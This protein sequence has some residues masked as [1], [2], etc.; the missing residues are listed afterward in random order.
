MDCRRRC[1]PRRRITDRRHE[2]AGTLSRPRNALVW[3]RRRGGRRDWR[4]AEERDRDRRRRRR[5]ARARTQCDGRA[6]HAWSR[7]DLAVRV[8]R[9]RASRYARRIERSRRSRRHVHGRSEPQSLTS[10]S[11]SVAGGRSRT[12]CLRCTWWPRGC[13]RRARRS[14]WAR[15]TSSSCRSRRRCRQCSRGTDVAAR[16]GGDV[17]GTTRQKA[18]IE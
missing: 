12:S 3:Q 14:H 16:S 4:R 10:G 5:G 1:W 7:G 15:V 6:D 13:A 11:N 2:S 9:R 18:E 17:D 8:R